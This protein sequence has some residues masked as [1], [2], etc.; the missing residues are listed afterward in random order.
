M[1]G[2]SD[3]AGSASLRWLASYRHPRCYDRMVTEALPDTFIFPRSLMSGAEQAGDPIA[4]LPALYHPIWRH[5]LVAD[6][7]LVLSDRTVAGVAERRGVLRWRHE[8][9]PEAGS[10]RSTT[11]PCPWRSGRRRRPP[12]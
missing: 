1:L 11:R 12:S 10:A 2:D 4:V 7:S 9:Y 6:P 5:A 3:P 8:P